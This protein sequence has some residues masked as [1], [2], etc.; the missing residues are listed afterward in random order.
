ME[1]YSPKD[2]VVDI[3]KEYPTTKILFDEVGHFDSFVSVEVFCCNNFIDFFAFWNRMS[4]KRRSK[5]KKK[6]VST[7]LLNNK[8][9]KSKY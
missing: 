4:E 7:L 2:K 6:F 8:Q 9:R 1:L 3:I 5:R